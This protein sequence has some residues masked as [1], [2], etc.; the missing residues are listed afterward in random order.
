MPAGAIPRET[1]VQNIF[2]VKHARAGPE[3]SVQAIRHASAHGAGRLIQRHRL[4]SVDT[5]PP[6]RLTSAAGRFVE[7]TSAF[8]GAMK[9]ARGVARWRT[10]AGQ[11]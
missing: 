4:V 8:S 11:F 3:H 9:K 6:A 1:V 7:L 2:D 10:H 5:L